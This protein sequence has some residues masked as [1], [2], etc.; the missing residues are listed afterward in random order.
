MALMRIVKIG[1]YRILLNN[2]NLYVPV[3]YYLHTEVY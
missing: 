2:F 1:K 3:L